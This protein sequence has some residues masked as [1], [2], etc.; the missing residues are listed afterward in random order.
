MYVPNIPSRIIGIGYSDNDPF[1]EVDLG[2]FP[3]VNLWSPPGMPYACIEPLVTHHD[4][5]NSPMEIEKK[6]G[7]VSLPTQKSKSYYFSIIIKD[8]GKL[9]KN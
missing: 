6:S 7:M 4:M 5:E 3:N 1:V 2:N 8:L 9:K